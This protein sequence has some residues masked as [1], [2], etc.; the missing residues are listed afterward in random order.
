MFDFT[1][2]HL[3]FTVV[4]TTPIHLEPFKGSALRGA[5][6]TYMQK[7]F[8]SAPPH[9]RTDPLHQEGCPVCYLTN[10]DTGPETRRPFTLQPPLS[11][12]TGYEPG[13]IFAFGFTL[14]GNAQT[15]FPYVL[16]GWHEVGETLGLGHFIPA[17]R[18]RGR[19]RLLQVEAFDPHTD[20]RQIVYRREAGRMVEMPAVA[21]TAESIAQRA[22]RLAETLAS[23][24][25]LLTLRL[26]TPLRLIHEERL[27][28]RF[29]FVP[30]FQRLLERL[31]AT[32]AHFS[33]AAERF[34]PT[35][36]SEDVRQLLPVAQTVRVVTDR[37]HWWDV[38]G[39]SQ[40]KGGPTHLGGLVGD[41]VLWAPDW[42][43][44]LPY[45]LWGE[46]IQLGKNVV[47]G[48][49]WYGLVTQGVSPSAPVRLD[50]VTTQADDGSGPFV[51]DPAAAPDGA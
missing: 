9:A 32:A 12:Q 28:H 33:A 20:R 47:K 43:P 30:F 4:A 35:A 15:L 19:F 49:G 21:V 39:Y 11:R 13:E 24:D 29:A 14:F 17:L 1:L 48:C 40:R 36:L 41:V 37:S 3:R 27:M 50:T 26:L 23:G 42:K 44:L 8:C 18:G 25:G 31:Y 51:A 2:Y 6:H 16:L 34:T 46:S 10:R 22:T 7:T 45:L 5:W 38:T